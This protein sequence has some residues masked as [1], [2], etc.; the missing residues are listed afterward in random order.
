M[1]ARD[2]ARDLAVLKVLGE[3]VRDARTALEQE[4]RGV[5]EPGDRMAVKVAD[6]LLAQVTLVNGRRT[7]RVDDPDALLDWVK[8]NHPTEVQTVESVRPAFLAMLLDIAK[9][10]GFGVHPD[11]GDVVPGIAVGRGEPYPQVR[12][13]ADAEAL[14]AVE[15]QAGRLPAPLLVALGAGPSESKEEADA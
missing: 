7:A 6:E 9:D 15:W 5:M 10:A 11:T 13:S 4:A 12:L 1:S 3:R 2:I 8:A 14:V